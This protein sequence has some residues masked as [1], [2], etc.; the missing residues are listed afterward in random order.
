[1]MGGSFLSATLTK[2]IAVKQPQVGQQYRHV[3]TVFR[4]SV[5]TLTA[6]VVGADG[7]EHAHLTA[8]HDVTQRKTIALSVI[9]DPRQLTL[10]ETADQKM[11]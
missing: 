8:A 2:V 10:V 3:G 4:D 1:M 6:I 7:I 9:A 5:W 11:Q